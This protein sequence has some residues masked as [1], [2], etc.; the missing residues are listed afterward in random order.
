MDYQNKVNN[1]INDGIAEG[2]Y[3]EAVE[4]THKDLKRF[5]R[6]L[7]RN[8]YKHE[9][10]ENMRPKSNQP[11]SYF[12]TAK[13]HKFDSIND[14]TLD[15]LKFRPVIDQTRKYIYNASK[16]VGKYLRPLS[17]NKYS[18]NVTLTFPDL[19]GNAEKSEDYEDVSYDVEN[20]FMSTS[21]KEWIDYIIRE[22]YVKTEIKPFCKSLFLK[23]Y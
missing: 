10:Y 11:G 13:T 3:I 2:K 9:Q 4:N 19:L 17:K 14:I 20:L 18:I 6:F 16:A 12:A 23:N 1:M 21:V 5:Q 15:Q 22:I 7:Y 8:L